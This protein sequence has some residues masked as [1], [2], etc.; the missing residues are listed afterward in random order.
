[1]KIFTTILIFL[2][3]LLNGHDVFAQEASPFQIHPIDTEIKLEAGKNMTLIG[4]VVR[5][6]QDH[7]LY[8]DKTAFSVTAPVGVKIGNLQTP[9]VVTKYDP[10][11]KKNLQIFPGS[12][13]EI[14]LTRTIEVPA[15]ENVKA[16]PSYLLQTTFRYQ[17]CGPKVCY[18][19]TTQ[20][21][22]IKIQRL[23]SEIDVKITKPSEEGSSK[24]KT[25]EQ[26]SWNFARF[27]QRGLWWALLMAF[28]GGLLSSLTPCVYPMI[29]ITISVIG[30]RQAT[31]KMQSLKLGG[32]FSIGLALTY[33]LLGVI[34]ASTGS[35]LGNLLQ[36]SLVVVG[37]AAVFIVMGLSMLGVFDFRLPYFMNRFIAGAD[38]KTGL[39]GVLF[40]GMI[41]GLVAAPCVGP[42]VLG[43]LTFVATSKNPVL[44]FS[45]LFSF[46]LG[47]STLFV[48]LGVFT[49]WLNRIPKSGAW[50]DSVKHLFGFG[51]VGVGIYY[52]NPLM[53]LFSFHLLI[54]VVLI[55]SPS[56]AGS[57]VGARQRRS[58]FECQPILLTP[59]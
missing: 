47:L 4:V 39:F 5:L 9:Q 29:P 30:A 50:M 42:V 26:E 14:V 15:D 45:L 56:L 17:G 31:S 25:S 41:T 27:T 36:N 51:M 3:A 1:V 34:A 46:A 8:V 16:L 48:F 58:R 13:G 23:A 19:P 37:I 40:T 28:I 57:T 10:T 54:F 59:I 44:G 53:N 52:L 18:L 21:W 55:V 22:T 49:S 35:L 32:L 2:G 24:K 33:A 7:Y 12:S 20:Q 11:L 43:I 6:P 38:N